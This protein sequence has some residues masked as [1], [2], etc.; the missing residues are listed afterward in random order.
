MPRPIQ[1]LGIFTFFL[2]VAG[3]SWVTTIKSCARAWARR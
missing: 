3:T 1:T 2:V